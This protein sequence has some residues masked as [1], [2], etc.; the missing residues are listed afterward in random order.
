MK[1]KNI[2]W[3]ALVSL[4]LIGGGYALN[5]SQSAQAKTRYTTKTTPVK[6]RGTWYSRTAWAGKMVI[7]KHAVRWYQQTNGKWQLAHQL[8]GKKLVVR[9]DK[10]Q[11]HAVFGFFTP[12]Q[13]YD[14]FSYLTTEKVDG[15][16]TAAL[17]NLNG[18]T[19]YHTM[20]LAR[21]AD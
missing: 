14:D 2:W 13:K 21:A 20:P 10:R 7:Q 19:Y 4:G 12:K 15:K 17:V 3:L 8:K 6:A 1:F 11:N 9:H 5:S 18:Y 16:R